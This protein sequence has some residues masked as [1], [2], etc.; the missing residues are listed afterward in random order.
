M[1]VS[2]LGW[3]SEDSFGVCSLFPPL[4][5]FP[6][7]NSG[8]T[9]LCSNYLTPLNCVLK[10]SIL[11]QC[12]FL[13]GKWCLKGEAV[14]ELTALS[15]VC[16]LRCECTGDSAHTALHELATSLSSTHISSPSCLL[17]YFQTALLISLSHTLKI[18]FLLDMVAYTLN[19]STWGRG[20]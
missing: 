2:V 10:H 12:Y 11:H 20:R 3:K 8:Q 6:G 14:K 17:K 1:C 7:L 4:H 16:C 5:V 19:P 15:E 9:G 18:C 13:Q